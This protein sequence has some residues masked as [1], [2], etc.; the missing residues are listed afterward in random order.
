MRIGFDDTDGVQKTTGGQANKPPAQ[1]K[2]KEGAQQVEKRDEL[3][4]SK[5]TKIEELQEAILDAHANGNEELVETLRKDL[6]K[7]E[8]EKVKLSSQHYA[9][10]GKA[11]HENLKDIVGDQNT[12]ADLIADEKDDTDE[13]NE[14]RERLLAAQI[15]TTLL[16]EFIGNPKN[17]DA[18]TKSLIN[19][20]ILI[21]ANNLKGLINSSEEE[22]KELD[23]ELSD[24]RNQATS[25]PSSTNIKDAIREARQKLTTTT[26]LNSLYKDSLEQWKKQ[27]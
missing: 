24:L 10:L 2:P 9:K 1:S 14:T 4:I 3:T 17:L 27:F 21:R 5:E 18:G 7:L 20:F 11:L 8:P 25:D 26:V 19:K 15:R 23:D 22:I 16:E 13:A 12:L 6:K